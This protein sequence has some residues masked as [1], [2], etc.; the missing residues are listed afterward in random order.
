MWLAFSAS[1]FS[2]RTPL[3]GFFLPNFLLLLNDGPG[4]IKDF[5]LPIH[6]IRMPRLK[7]YRISKEESVFFY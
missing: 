4:N 3:L 1:S 7:N 6:Q 2:R 5:A